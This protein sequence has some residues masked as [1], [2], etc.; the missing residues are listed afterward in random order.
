MSLC[1]KLWKITK[2]LTCFPIS[3]GC[4]KLL[5]HIFF[6]DSYCRYILSSYMYINLIWLDYQ[7]L[8]VSTKKVKSKQQTQVHF[9][10][11]IKIG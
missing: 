11:V 8:T 6:T 4:P 2:I 7:Q 9:L 5:S 10:A 1:C 3:W